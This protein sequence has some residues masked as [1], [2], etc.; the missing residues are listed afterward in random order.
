[1][2]KKY[3]LHLYDS[4]LMLKQDSLFKTCEKASFFEKQITRSSS[5]A[6]ERIDAQFSDTSHSNTHRTT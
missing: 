6:R 2:K 3:F 1:M 5:G 4:W